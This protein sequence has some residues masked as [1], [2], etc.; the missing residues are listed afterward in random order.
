M[1]KRIM[2]TRVCLVALLLLLAGCASPPPPPPDFPKLASAIKFVGC[3]SV[4]CAVIWSYAI[5]TSSNN[6]KGG[7]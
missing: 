2:P 6:R 1:L 7:K 4:I 5:V 3:C